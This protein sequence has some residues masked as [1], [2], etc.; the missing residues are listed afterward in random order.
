MKYYTDKI[1][2][3]GLILKEGDKVYLLRRNLKTKRLSSKLDWKKLG[4]FKI[5]T[6]ISEVNYRLVLLPIMKI[7][8][9]FYILLF[10]PVPINSKLVITVEL[11]E[12]Q[13]YEVE[14][15]LDKR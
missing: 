10:E 13:E 11:D 5:E 14:R 1:R 6:K 15:I 8:L 2:L 12:N 9:V 4:P 3:K 7:Y